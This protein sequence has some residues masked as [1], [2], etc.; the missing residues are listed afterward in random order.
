MKSLLPIL[1]SLLEDASVTF[2]ADTSRDRMEILLRHDHEGDGYL[3]ITLPTFGAWLE[4]SLE[5]GRVQTA[6]YRQFKR[7]P[8]AVGSVLPCFLQ[9][10]TSLVF[11]SFSGKVREDANPTAVFFIRQ[12]CYLFKKPK[13]LASPERD[14]KAHRQYEETDL[15]VLSRDEVRER[16]T[17]YVRRAAS[18]LLSGF[19][20][21]Y[22]TSDAKPKHGPGATADK[23]RGNA[24]YTCRDWYKRWDNVFF[25]EDLYGYTIVTEEDLVEIAEED[26][27][28]VKVISVPKTYKTTRIISIEPTAMQMAQQLV[29]ARMISA[30]DC[31]MLGH[32][33]R[34]RDQSLNRHRAFLGS[35]M[36]GGIATIDLSE[37][38]D[39]VSLG[40]VQEIFETNCPVLYEHLMAVRT[41]R[42]KLS[43]GRVI[44][45]KKFA[46]MGSAVTFPVESVVFAILAISAVALDYTVNGDCR[47]YLHALAKAAKE[48]STYGDDIVVPK[49][50]FTSVCNTLEL[51]GL[52][53]NLRKSFAQGLF[54]ESCGGDYYAGVDVTPAYCRHMRPRGRSDAEALVSF[55]SLSNQ[56]YSKG[57]WRAADAV[58]LL[59]EET[60]GHLPLK[61]K[62]ASYLGW[63]HYT[64]C[65]EY[66]GYDRN[67][68]PVVQSY[69]PKSKKVRD[70]LDGY[71]AL[72]KHQLSKD[73]QES[74]SHLEESTERHSLK[75]RKKRTVV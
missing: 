27:M 61:R 64:D 72:L 25:R 35:F 60:T 36:N 68:T 47:D 56:L 10:L 28:P 18:F 21:A 22:T 38:S 14:A 65:Y 45:L 53:V 71:G 4:E 73:V 9:G 2:G 62:D 31:G 26:E 16:M 33:I 15:E 13:V 24:K 30:I 5:A 54:R 34:L 69:V 7:K 37:A 6:I 46:S 39:R 3:T 32:G 49:G 43:D 59:V 11:E 51:F 19:D 70:N 58:K 66:I 63:E 48:V 41:S 1:F 50:S 44:A 23:L 42:A 74:S 52:K 20:H 75:L 40:L 67:F 8:K 29:A 17:W 55:V 57:C 12:I